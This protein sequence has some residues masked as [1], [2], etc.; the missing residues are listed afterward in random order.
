MKKICYVVTIPGTIRSFFIPQLNYLANNGF[1][2]SVICSDDGMIDSEL[3]DLVKFI[4][5]DIPRGISVFGS[6]KAI[7]KLKIIFR[8]E[9]FDVI[10]YSTPNAALY[11]S[12]AAKW[13][14]CKIRNYHL[15]GLRY[16]GAHGIGRKVLKT[17]EKITCNNSTSIECVSKSNM[18]L[19]VIEGLF[20]SDKVT[21]VWNGSTGGVD[22]SR[23]D[24]SQRKK[25]RSEVRK[26]LGYTE[27]DFIYGFVGRITRDK[28]INEL[29]KAF[30]SLKSDANLLLIGR[31]EHEEDLDQGLLTTAKED[32]KIC[33]HDAVTNIEEYYAAIDVLVL[34]SYREGFGN[35]IIEAGAVGTPAIVSN[36]PG[37]ID[38]IIQNETA[39]VVPV[40]DV[41]AL[42]ESLEQI[43]K[44]DYNAMGKKAAQFAREKFDSKILCEKILERKQLL[45]DKVVV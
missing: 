39:L 21:V 17:L 41:H 13:A 10:Q 14:G 27:D 5:V 31:F 2:V 19:G 15:M 42:T 33:F 43:R 44:V 6:I 20:P 8:R 28:G 4:P 38:T 35:V 29:L 45:I 23:F 22:L 34:P 16:L 1:D 9:K 25:W 30:F 26:K 36:I 12:I 18:K 7:K 24:L 37:P 32:K 3:G 40:K 11:S